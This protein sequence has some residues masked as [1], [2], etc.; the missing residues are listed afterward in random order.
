[1]VD[2][3]YRIVCLLVCV[4]LSIHARVL[5]ADSNETL[6]QYLCSS[7]GQAELTI[8][9]TTLQLIHNNSYYLPVSDSFCVVSNFVNL[10]IS[11]DGTEV[12]RIVCQRSTN[13]SDFTINSGC[14]LAFKD[15]TGLKLEKIAFLLFG[16]V[17]QY[18]M[19]GNDNSTEL[20]AYFGT[21]Q[22]A[23]F[24]MSNVSHLNLST[25]EISDYYGYAIIVVNSLGKN[26]LTDVNVER[27]LSQNVCPLLHHPIAPHNYSCF[28]SGLL[29]YYHDAVQ[30]D[31]AQHF[32]NDVLFTVVDSVFINNIYKDTHSICIAN[33]FQFQPERVPIVAGAGITVYLT[34]VTFNV[35]VKFKGILITK[36]DGAISGGLAV[37]FIN[38]PFS[39]YVT[40]ENSVIRNNHNSYFPCSGQSI[41]VYTYFTNSFLSSDIARLI[42]VKN[43]M[44]SWVSLTIN[45]TD[46]TDNVGYN[47]SSSVYIGLRAQSLYEIKAIIEDVLFMDNRAFYTGICMLVETVYEP[48]SSGSTKLI[49]VD[50]KNINATLNSQIKNEGNVILSNSSQF[51]FYRVGRAM[52]EGDG[53][54][55]SSFIN[56]VGSVIDAFASEVYLK[57]VVEFKHNQAAVGAAI[58]LRS[59]SFLIFGEDSFI[60]FENNLAY[61]KGGAI[62]SEERGTEDYYC[63]LQ[64]DSNKASILHSNINV[65]ISNNTALGAGA[66]AYLTPLFHCFQTRFHVFPR[67]LSSLYC[68][69]FNLDE[70]SLATQ[71]STTPTHICVCTLNDTEYQPDCTGT[72]LQ[73]FEIFPGEEVEVHL[74][75]YDDIDNRVASL[76]NASL[77]VINS[78]AVSLN[79]WYIP[80][81]QVIHNIVVK[82]DCSPFK[83][84][85]YSNNQ[86]IQKGQLNFAIPDKQPLSSVEIHM[87]DCPPGFTLSNKGECICRKFFKKVGLSCEVS[88]KTIRK[89]S[90]Y[91]W[92]GIIESSIG[93]T[94]YC[95]V[96]YC[97]VSLTNIQV[98]SSFPNVCINNRV[99]PL[100]GNCREGYSAEHGGV[101]CKLCSKKNLWWLVGNV[102][103]GLIAVVVLFFLEF[104]INHGTIAGIVFYANTFSFI[105]LSLNANKSYFLPFLQVIEILNLHQA[106]PTCLFN[107]M[108]HAYQYIIAYAYSAYLWVIVICVIIFAR[109]SPR[110]SHLLMRSSVQV[111]VTLIHLSFA[112]VLYVVIDTFTYTQMKTEEKSYAVWFYNGTIQYGTGKHIY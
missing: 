95:P 16:S 31:V 80:S 26:I 107:G 12:V 56:N 81:Q 17:L 54:F 44:Q 19:L 92:I 9:D 97:N 3:C 110:L 11:S 84:R 103:S 8:P 88:N 60:V 23:S 87:K 40:I 101:G 89:Y 22:T 67:H 63:V 86:T 4:S 13:A 109:F 70:D 7:V 37:I 55:G 6:Y 14:G 96:G 1:M 29:I 76:V 41:L 28:G 20:Y 33:V 99:G 53:P 112:K 94:K 27:S 68:T 59:G 2:Y 85:V 34:Q 39:S 65:S 57:G 100:C 5:V 105:R 48:L 75:A 104:T 106:F 58:L 47:R 90:P 72:T 36:N 21:N 45:G 91:N 73:P 82:K 46:I 35:S 52:I 64:I 18:H 49:Q 38:T 69:L 25:I 74:I 78:T 111:L 10:T 30:Y 42:G 43:Y 15:G 93:F 83:Y 61:E 32:D 24:F 77:S 71:L 98:A 62:Y 102:S 66:F 51:V 108:E 79:G 50:L